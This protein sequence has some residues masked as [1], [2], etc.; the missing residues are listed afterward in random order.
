MPLSPKTP[1][2]TA[3]LA[4]LAFAAAAP[5]AA[6]AAEGFAGISHGDRLVTFHSDTI[7]SVSAA[8]DIAGL[9]GG[10]RIVALDALPGSPGG[11]LLA[12]GTSGT[13]YGLDAAHQKVTRTVAGFGAPVVAGAPIAL[14]AAPDGK[15]A[16]VIAGG[17]D[18]TLDLATGAVVSDVPGAVPIPAGAPVTG[19]TTVT[20]TADGAQWILTGI[21]TRAHQPRQS[22]LFRYDPATGKLRGQGSFFFEQLDAIAATGTVADDTTAPAAPVRI[23]RQSVRDALR[24]RGFVAIV[25]TS[26]P[27]QTVMSARL[28]GQY[29]GFG[30]GTAMQRGQL[31]VLASEKQSSIRKLAGQRLRLHIAVRDWAGNTRLIDQYFTLGR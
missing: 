2:L 19:P 11:E 24:H 7:P 14:D 1:L 6:S 25:T 10:E 8:R 29:K 22:H 28:G 27:G 31:R 26:E 23:P 16:R 9:P 18:K 4:G 30:F 13:V 15:T 3:A 21:P 20:T 17:R 12:L 5:A